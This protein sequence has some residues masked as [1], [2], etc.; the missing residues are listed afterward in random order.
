MCVCPE[1]EDERDALHRHQTLP[2]HHDSLWLSALL[3]VPPVALLH[4]RKNG[5]MFNEVIQT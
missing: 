4:D 3:S 2:G 5:E 1:Q